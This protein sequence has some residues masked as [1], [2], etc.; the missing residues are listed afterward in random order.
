MDILVVALVGGTVMFL[1]VLRELR[2]PVEPD[3]SPPVAID[4]SLEAKEKRLADLNAELAEAETRTAKRERQI[5]VKL[6][7]LTAA[8]RERSEAAAD[9]AK[10]EAAIARRERNVERSLADAERSAAAATARIEAREA[11]VATQEAELQRQ[12]SELADRRRSV[13]EREHEL[14]RARASVSVRMDPVPADRERL[15][16]KRSGAV[17]REE[18]VADFEVPL[19]KKESDLAQL[20]RS[21]S[22]E[23]AVRSVR[24][25]ADPALD[26]R[27]SDWW[28]KQLGRPLSAKK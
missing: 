5:A 26:R 25:A 7:E 3:D 8:E 10:Q 1:L 23:R 2:R 4:F 13:A 18:R 27:M 11:V 20:A 24:P 17:Q 9:L 19:G 22:E 12:E 15:G 14:V 6:R 16:E 21:S 28:E